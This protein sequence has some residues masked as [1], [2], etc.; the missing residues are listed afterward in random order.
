[1]LVTVMDKNIATPALLSDNAPLLPEI[2]AITN[3][4]VFTCS[5]ILFALEQLKKAE[6]KSQI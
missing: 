1:M 6:E 2:V 4:L 3:A 5:I